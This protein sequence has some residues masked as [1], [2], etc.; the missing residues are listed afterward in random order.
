MFCLL[1]LQIVDGFDFVNH[2]GVAGSFFD[3]GLDEVLQEFFQLEEPKHFDDAAAEI[4]VKESVF[5]EGVKCPVNGF[6]FFLVAAVDD[7]AV[8]ARFP[9]RFSSISATVEDKNSLFGG[10]AVDGV[11]P[12]FVGKHNFWFK[13][14]ALLKI[15]QKKKRKKRKCSRFDKEKYGAIFFCKKNGRSIFDAY[16]FCKKPGRA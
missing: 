9:E 6:E 8:R 3:A 14:F 7:K 15:F 10:W 11:R 16:F 2:F 13:K 5:P 1:L 12:Y 4:R